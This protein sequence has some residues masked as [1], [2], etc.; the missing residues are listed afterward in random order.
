MI[1]DQ[2]QAEIDRYVHHYKSPRYGMGRRRQHDVQRILKG[3]RPGSL[4]D[5]GTGRGETLR[6]AER[7]NHG[8]VKGVEVVPYL[9]DGDRVIQGQAHALPFD[10][11]AFDH[12]T[13]FDVL[14]HLIEEDLEPTLRELYRVAR[15][16]VTVSA[17]ERP[18]IWEGVDLHISKRPRAEWLKMIR[19]CWNSKARCI[20]IAGGSPA[21]Q[22]SI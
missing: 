17:S 8:P 4:L 12:V 19:S 22:L 14:E 11:N 15:V 6:F 2:R 13:C 21:F 9:C 16:S 5:V 3:L 18:S 20:G 10:D 1:E 7:V